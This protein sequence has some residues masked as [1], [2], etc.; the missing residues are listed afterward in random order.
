MDLAHVHPRAVG[1]GAMRFAENGRK[2]R[3]APC[4]PAWLAW[5]QAFAIKKPEDW[6]AWEQAQMRPRLQSRDWHQRYLGAKSFVAAK[7]DQRNDA[8]VLRLQRDLAVDRRSDP[9]IL[10]AFDHVLAEFGPRSAALPA[11]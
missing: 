2:K 3:G 4:A 8:D 6:Q 10:R 7:L 11:R 5:L 1:G 9:A